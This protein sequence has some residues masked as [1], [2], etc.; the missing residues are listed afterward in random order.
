MDGDLNLRFFTVYGERQRP[1]SAI[2]KFADAIFHDRSVTMY[3]DG[4]TARDYTHVKDIVNGI[5]SAITFLIPKH[6]ICE[7]INLG[8]HSPIKLKDMIVVL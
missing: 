7:T 1:D 4:E 3:G 5:A 8:N 6:K 2:Y